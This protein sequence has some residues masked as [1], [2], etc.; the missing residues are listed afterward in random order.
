MEKLTWEHKAF[1]DFS[2]PE[3]HA[4]LALRQA[5][6]VV[7]QDC[8]YL[9]ADDLDAVSNHF[10]ARDETGLIVAYARITAPGTRFEEPS[11]GRVLVHFQQRGTGRGRELMARAIEFARNRYPGHN[12]RVSAQTYLLKFY[13]ELGFELMGAPYDDEGIE[14]IDML[15]RAGSFP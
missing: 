4:L 2:G 8:A 15:L 12:V 9:D 10:L 3:M 1:T 14:H 6:F 5:V 11:I 7:E 13:Q